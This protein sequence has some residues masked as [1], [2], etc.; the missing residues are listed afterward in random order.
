MRTAVIMGKSSCFSSSFLVLHVFSRF[1]WYKKNCGSA[2]MT[3]MEILFSPEVGDLEQIQFI[4]EKEKSDTLK[5][6][7]LTFIHVLV[8]KVQSTQ[9]SE[10]L[11]AGNHYSFSMCLLSTCPVPDPMVDV[12]HGEV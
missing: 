12:R 7:R 10:W 3:K 2:L 11:M 8:V 6:S 1:A 9:F 4:S 5:P